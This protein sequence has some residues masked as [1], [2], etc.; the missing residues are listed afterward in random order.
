MQS[1]DGNVFG[2]GA[3]LGCDFTGTV[4]KL[5]EK[6]ATAKVG[7]QIAGLIW[8]AT[9]HPLLPHQTFSLLI[10]LFLGESLGLGEYSQYTIADSKIL[11]KVPDSISSADASTVFLAAGT[12]QLGALLRTMPEYLKKA[13]ERDSGAGLERSC[14]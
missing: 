3:V 13:K 1:L 5:G 9:R 12:A 10:I 8:G 14:K 11:F 2:K 7:H 6:V 4:E